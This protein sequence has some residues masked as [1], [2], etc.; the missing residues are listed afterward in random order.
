MFPQPSNHM[1]KYIPD[2]EEDKKPTKAMSSQVAPHGE[3]VEEE[4][5][6][7]GH[8][9]ESETRETE[10]EE[11]ET[12]IKLTPEFQK[13]VHGILHGATKEELRWIIQEATEYEREMNKAE[14]HAG[15]DRNMFNMEGLPE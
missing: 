11:G 10:I 9:E 13:E 6:D 14:H 7:E 4:G 5:E 8:D 1:P 12:N 15:L 3:D 2:D